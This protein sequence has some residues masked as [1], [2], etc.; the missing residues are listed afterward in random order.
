MGGWLHVTTAFIM[1]RASGVT[2]GWVDKVDDAPLNTMIEEVLTRAHKE[3]PVRGIWCVN[4]RDFSMWVNTSS[5][6]NSVLLKY[7]A[8]MVEDVC[9]L[10]PEKDSQHINLTELDALIKGVNLAILWKMT[11]LHLFT[12]SACVH[13]WVSDTL[14]G[15]ARMRTKATSEMLI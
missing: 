4:G 6:A 5:L 15:R 11:T 1:W 7:G 12:N 13:K 8:T 2:T 10:Q 9:W 14:T 3:D